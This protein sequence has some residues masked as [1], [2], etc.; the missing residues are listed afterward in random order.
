M[1]RLRASISV[2]LWNQMYKCKEICLW[3]PQTELLC[4]ARIWK[5]LW[6]PGW[7]S[8]PRLLKGFTN[9]SC[10]PDLARYPPPHTISNKKNNKQTLSLIIW[11]LFLLLKKKWI[12]FP[13]C[14]IT[15]RGFAHFGMKFIKN[16]VLCRKGMVLN[17]ITIQ[18]KPLFRHLVLS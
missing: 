4:R 16:L 7:E 5:N 6:S 13:F 8:I 1:L 3:N 14:H 15:G 12:L 2:G 10:T 17:I 11:L 9:T 18:K